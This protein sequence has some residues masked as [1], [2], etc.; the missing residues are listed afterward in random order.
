[1]GVGED[2]FEVRKDDVKEGGNPKSVD[3]VVNP[4]NQTPIMK[5]S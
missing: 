4:Q 3:G 5:F 1:M 2:T